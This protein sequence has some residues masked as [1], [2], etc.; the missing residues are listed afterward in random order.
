M[1]RPRSVLRSALRIV[2]GLAF[3]LAALSAAWAYGSIASLRPTCLPTSARSPTTK[4]IRA[5]QIWSAGRRAHRRIF[6][7]KA[8]AAAHRANPRPGSQRPL[9]PLRTAASTTWRGRLPGRSARGLG[10]ICVR[11]QR[12]AR[13]LQHHATGG[14]DPHRRPGTFAGAQGTRSPCSPFRIEKTPA[15]GPDSRHLPQ[16]RI[17]WPWRLWSG[18]SRHGLLRQERSRKLTVARGCHA[19]GAPKRLATSTP[20]ARF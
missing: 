3:G 16:P 4:P 13:R 9:S 17:P 15:Q 18:V 10:P 2:G 1:S 20:L 14:Q 12:A 7:G 5:S 11:G 6:R 8:G 19:G